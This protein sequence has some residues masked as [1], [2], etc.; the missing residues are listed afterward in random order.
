[1]PSILGILLHDF[2]HRRLL[3]TD[4]L[5][6]GSSGL[7]HRAEDGWPVTQ[8]R[9]RRRNSPSEVCWRPP[10]WAH[11]PRRHQPGGHTTLLKTL[12]STILNNDYRYTI[13]NST[14]TL[15]SGSESVDND[16][17]LF[18]K[19]WWTVSGCCQQSLCRTSFATAM[20]YRSL[21]QISK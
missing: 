3:V 18:T 17:I 7:R 11:W 10:R 19:Y 6:S 14:K 21:L 13:T 4:P 16:Q 20:H 12:S 5:L 1:M 2:C 9:D 15:F 8:W